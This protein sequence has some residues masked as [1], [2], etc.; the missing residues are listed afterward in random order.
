MSEI[1]RSLFQVG[2]I[3]QIV[4]SSTNL[5]SLLSA[6]TTPCFPR[7]MPL[8]H[9]CSAVSMSWLSSTKLLSTSCWIR[10]RVRA[11][12]VLAPDQLL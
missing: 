11:G 5:G 10:K 4:D 3:P 7:A 1:W 8:G 2:D 12:S 6:R 9:L